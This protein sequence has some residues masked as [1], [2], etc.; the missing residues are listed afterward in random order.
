MLNVKRAAHGR[1]G[2][3]RYRSPV[4]ITHICEV[5]VSQYITGN[6]G[7]RILDALQSVNIW[8]LM[9][10]SLWLCSAVDYGSKAP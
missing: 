7:F 1:P 8:H 3:V 9:Q 6:N 2:N 5:F 10:L 4:I